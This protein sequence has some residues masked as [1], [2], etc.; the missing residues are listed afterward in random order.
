MVTIK[1][2]AEKCGLSTAAVSR[3]LN[4]LPGVS[5]ENAERVRHIAAEMG[6]IPNAAA[7]LLKTSRSNMIGILYRNEIV[8]EFFSSVLEGIHQEAERHGYEL[9]FLNQYPGTSYLE[10]AHHRQCAG[11]VVVQGQLY[12]Y[13]NV[14]SLV[15]GDIPTVSVEYEYPGGTM[16]VTDNVA[17]MEELIHHLHDDMGHSR[18]AFI[19][20]ESCQVSSERLAGF[21]RG[22]R[23]CGLTI[24]DEYV[25]QG[26]FR[27]PEA[28]ALRTGELLSLPLPPT[29]ILYPDD[30]SYLGGVAEIQRRGLS[31]PSD[32]SCVGF[33]GQS[34]ARALTPRLT[35][36]FQD[37]IMMGARAA[38]ELISAIE[39]PRCDV[40]RTVHV[41][42]HILRGETVRDL[43]GG[44]QP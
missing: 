44:M 33:D 14:M 41:P 37:G 21:V 31:V 25:R 8:H 35:T 29:C 13:D 12:D 36:Y 5:Q 4:H 30:V 1:M 9:V 2:I 19:L 20:G 32:V 34:L 39:D 26:Y 18:I 10:H 27:T 43:R 16:V 15:Q 6:Y 28:S 7:R 42:G 24:P 22:C 17:A 40:P 38:Q 23:S 11:V 3:A